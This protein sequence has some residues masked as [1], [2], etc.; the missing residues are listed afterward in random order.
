MSELKEGIPLRE[1]EAA[2]KVKLMK[3]RYIKPELKDLGLLRLVTKLT[4]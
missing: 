3:K 4:F 2:K 1:L